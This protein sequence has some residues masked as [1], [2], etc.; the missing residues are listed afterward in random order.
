MSLFSM[1]KKNIA[2]LRIHISPILYSLIN[3]IL[4]TKIDHVLEK[5]L[6]VTVKM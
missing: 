6:T 1:K 4:F 2:S 5:F 3:L